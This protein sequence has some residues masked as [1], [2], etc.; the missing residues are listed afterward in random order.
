MKTKKLALSALL[1]SLALALGYMERFLPLE[2]IVPLPGVKL[3]L[4]NVVTLYA[5]YA[6]EPLL[7]LAII[8]LRCLM[9]AFFGG[10][11]A[12]LAFSLAGGLLA[13]GAM[14]LS[15]RLPSL[16]EIGVSVLGAAGHNIGQI[17]A[18]AVIMRSPGVAAYL[19]VMLVAGIFT[20]VAIG[21]AVRRLVR[22]KI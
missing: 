21:F 14:L 19:P 8:V 15:K 20:G 17:A 22:I 11:A 13:Y 9:A 6:L 18:A 4:A 5:V 1:L 7:T 16:S 12:S 10:S 2:L 3:G